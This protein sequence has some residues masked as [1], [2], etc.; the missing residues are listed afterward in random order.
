MTDAEL[1]D[2]VRAIEARLKVADPPEAW[3]RTPSGYRVANR[4]HHV[5]P[6]IEPDANVDLIASAPADLRDLCAVIR[7]MFDSGRR[8]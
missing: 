7:Q 2:R 5:R 3:A 4:H 6:E 8:G 1:M